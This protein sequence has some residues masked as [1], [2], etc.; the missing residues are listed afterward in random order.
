MRLAING[1]VPEMDKPVDH[2]ADLKRES[3]RQVLIA[4]IRRCLPRQAQA[5]FD[6]LMKEMR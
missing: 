4:Q 6:E 3:R 5:W 2:L 1:L